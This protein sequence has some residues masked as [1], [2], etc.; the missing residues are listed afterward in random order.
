[1]CCQCD[2]LHNTVKLQGRSAVDVLFLLHLNCAIL[3]CTNFLMYSN[4]AFS[5][6]S[7]SI[8]QAFHGQSE[9]SQVFN[10]ENVSHYIS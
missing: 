3:E 1:M 8:Y 10:F 7:T 5:P 6:C 4:F 2:R 9:F